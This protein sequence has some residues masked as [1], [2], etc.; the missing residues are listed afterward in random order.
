MTPWN[1]WYDFMK[2]WTSYENEY[3]ENVVYPISPSNSIKKIARQMLKRRCKE[4]AI[5]KSI[6]S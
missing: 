3:N 1:L 6:Q 5:F 2:S 4:E